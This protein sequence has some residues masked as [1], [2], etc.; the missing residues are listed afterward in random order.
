MPGGQDATYNI[1][2]PSFATNEKK[3]AFVPVTPIEAQTGDASTQP[4]SLLLKK[5]KFGWKIVGISLPADD[6]SQELYSFENPLDV[7]K[8][9]SLI[10]GE[11][12]QARAT[13]NGELNRLE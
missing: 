1:G 8:I 12:R 2:E 13:E 4:F 10:D 9:K 6:Q 3:V 5:G 7:L 11:I